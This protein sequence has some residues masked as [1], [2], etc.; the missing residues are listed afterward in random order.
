MLGLVL[1]VGSPGW[2]RNSRAAS[3]GSPGSVGW[4]RNSQGSTPGWL[5]NSQGSSPGSPG[6]VGWLGIPGFYSR[7]VRNPRVL[8]QVLRVG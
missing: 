5:R 6:S 1:Q 3:P 8:L 7:L 4:L 2:L